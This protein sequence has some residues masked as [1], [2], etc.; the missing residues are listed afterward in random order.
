MSHATG[1]SSGHRLFIIYYRQQI[2]ELAC[3]RTEDTL[4]V[5]ILTIGTKLLD[6]R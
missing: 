1:G 2:H 3:I 4:I 6:Q 5:I